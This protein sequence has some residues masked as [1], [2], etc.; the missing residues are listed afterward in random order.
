MEVRKVGAIAV[1]K[2]LTRVDANSAKEM[3]AK[4]QEL[5]STGT[6][7]MICDFSEN[8]YISS[9]GLRVFLTVLKAMK[10]TGGSIVLCSLKS[11]VLEVF[12]MAG[13]SPLFCI[14]DTVD[15]GI[16]ELS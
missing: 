9:A 1:V 14:F 13:F 7:K 4:I 3:E 2:V 6:T 16:K 5:M 10:K 12:D 15:V 8:E 11:Y